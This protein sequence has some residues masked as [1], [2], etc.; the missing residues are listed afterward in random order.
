MHKTVKKLIQK[1]IFMNFGILQLKYK[2][3]KLQFFRFT[4]ISYCIDQFHNGRYFT[5]I[6]MDNQVLREIN[7]I[8]Y[9]SKKK[10][11]T[12]KIFN[13]LQVN[14]ISSVELH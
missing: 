5:I 12:I 10:T 2:F 9:V 14:G 8:K 11:C 6:I 4:D 1:S 3:Q 13:C 7:H